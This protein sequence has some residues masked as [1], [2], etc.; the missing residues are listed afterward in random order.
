MQ[1]LHGMPGIAERAGQTVGA[2][3]GAREHQHR[4]GVLLDQRQQQRGLVGTLDEVD[5]LSG[6]TGRHRQPAH[7]D[8]HG[9]TQVHA[10]QRTEIGRQ[11]RGEQERLPRCRQRR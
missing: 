6:M 5:V 10:R 7:V 1:A 8:T 11:R 9:I 4:A 3:F 2:M